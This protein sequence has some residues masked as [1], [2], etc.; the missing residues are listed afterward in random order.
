MRIARFLL[1]HPLQRRI[2]V[3]LVFACCVPLAALVI[4]LAWLLGSLARLRRADR[5]RLARFAAFGAVYLAVELTGIASVA[6]YWV[7]PGRLGRG[8]ADRTAFEEKHYRLLR[9][10]LERLFR[11]ARRSFEVRV[12]PPPAGSS[13]P[14]GPL[15]VASRHAG[16]GD[17]FLLA[18]ALLATVRRRPRFVLSEALALDPFIGTVLRRTPNCF[19]GLDEER[20]HRSIAR[21]AALARDLGTDDAL[22]IFPEGRNFTSARRERLIE[23]LRR[24]RAWKQLPA[25][26]ALEHVL[27]PRGSG[28]FAAIDAAPRE[29]H[30]V[31]VA[32]TGLDHMESARDAWRS[33]PLAARLEITWWSVPVRDIPAEPA[34]RED[35]L[36]LQWSQVDSWIGLHR[37][38]TP[39]DTAATPVPSPLTP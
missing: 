13:V 20:R 31:F 9:R 22:V 33:V 4:S 24:R 12:E 18:C 30:V 11:A 2:A 36:R 3:S 32:H 14:Q 28:V 34:R 1:R 25:A 27:P 8:P 5:G 29:T 23:R 19:V 37:A 10:L 6:L 7:G 35:W 21:I 38:A 15:I 17:S 39:P 16:P 26:R